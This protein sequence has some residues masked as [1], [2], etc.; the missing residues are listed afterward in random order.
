[1]NEQRTPAFTLGLVAGLAASL[2][3]HALVLGGAAFAIASFDS[4]PAEQITAIDVTVENQ[5][6]ASSEASSEQH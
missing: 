1:M 2:V 3:I 6:F 4:A 5:V